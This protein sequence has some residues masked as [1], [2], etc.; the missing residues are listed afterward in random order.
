[1]SDPLPRTPHH[2]R[3]RPTPAWFGERRYGL[4]VH[5][6]IA[7][8]PAFAPVHEYAEWY[9]SHL[10]DRRLDDVI[11]HPA[12]LPEV[13]VW[14]RT[15]HAGRTYDSF[16]DDLTL[17]R[18]DAD[19]IAELAVA[20]GMGYVIH[21]SKHHDGYCFFDSALTDRTSVRTGP[22]RDAVGELAAASRRVGLVHGLYY[23]LLDWSHPAYGT[24]AYVDEYLHPQVGELVE[25]YAP[26]VLWGDG[27]W[28]RPRE[29]WRSD[30][31]LDAYYRVLGSEGA[32]NDRWGAAHAD[33]VTFEYDTPTESPGR[34]F[35]VCRG[36]GYSF[37]WNRIERVD[38]H[39]TPSQ[40]VAL[41]TETIAKG[42]NLLINIGPRADGSIPDE[43]SEVLREAGRWVRANRTALDATVPFRWWGSDTIR[44]TVT[45]SDD[46]LIHLNVIDLTGSARLRLTE[47]P[48]DEFELIDGAEARQD[49]L[50]VTISC[51]TGPAPDAS[52]A[53]VHRLTVRPVGSDPPPVLR[54]GPAARLGGALHGSIAAALA[55]AEPG[56][57]VEVLDGRHH[58]EPFPLLVPAGVTLRGH[59]GAVLDADG[60][61]VEAIVRLVG[62]RAGVVGL[63][64]T[65]ASA[66]GFGTPPAG[67]LARDVADVAVSDCRLVRT[68]V[69]V[70]RASG[71]RI[72]DCELVGGGIVTIDCDATRISQNRQSGNRWGTGIEVRG[73]TGTVV[74]ANRLRD[75]LTG[76]AVRGSD[77]V[78]ITGNEVR[79]R[80]W[81]IHIDHAH[82]TTATGNEIDRTMRAVC[83][84]AAVDTRIAGTRAQGCDS[85]VLVESGS[86]GTVLIDNTVADCRLD[87]L[88]HDSE[89]PAITA[90]KT[91]RPRADID[92]PRRGTDQP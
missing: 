67:V 61:T 9:W 81:G 69:L 66:P 80:W 53:V 15:H 45:P 49:R 63:T 5:M 48:P 7:T 47:L 74:D 34:P 91:L 31:I 73:G 85:G 46:G 59:R 1:M 86:T 52:L 19:E 14:H 25:R 22:R 71:G 72:V 41:L 18:W 38:D 77:A 40:L 4:F 64:I 83:L 27:H 26:S 51:T 3:H 20:A 88:V 13:Q 60:A 33:Y 36:V 11:L 35:E 29:Y 17:D 57:V 54:N 10:S 70:E 79:T 6:A 12:P 44:Y 89:Q 32:V 21:T 75:D 24:D 2:T 30:A 50:G 82:R 65:G 78:A 58:T 56:D 23:S 43:Q 42:G 37:G 87:V 90:H 92:G 68:S 39:L 8:A 62:D 16:I 28:G 84:T 55:V 76:I